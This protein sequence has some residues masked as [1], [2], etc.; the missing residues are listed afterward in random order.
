MITVEHLCKSYTGPHGPVRVL[1]DV[2]FQVER[3]E[4][5]GIY[6]PSGVGKTT[7]LRCLS[8]LEKPDSG[9]IFIAG[10]K[11]STLAGKDARHV[12][13]RLGLSVVFQGYNLL[14]S[15]TALGNVMLPL[16]IRRV[17][18]AEARS[19]AKELLKL[20]GLGSRM[21]FY[22]SS[23]SGGEK[24]RVAIARALVTEPR[25]L[26]LDE[27]TSALDRETAISILQLVEKLNRIYSVTVLIVTHQ[28]E[29]ARSITKRGIF[30][31]PNGKGVEVI[32][33][34]VN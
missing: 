6:G 23:L 2:S 7:L 3:G 24:Q 5:F 13:L 29:L 10:E 4:I 33:N 15:R 26:L 30:M 21:D 9:D 31:S 14:N 25:V 22:P 19:K 32:E 1:N 20:T 34:V 16:E 27:P 28:I 8:L 17:P 11:V 18:K 12:R